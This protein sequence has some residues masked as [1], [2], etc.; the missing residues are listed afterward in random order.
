MIPLCAELQALSFDTQESFN[1]RH[2]RGES[3]KIH[4]G[5]FFMGHPLW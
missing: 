5:R 3:L 1:P 4:T 2:K